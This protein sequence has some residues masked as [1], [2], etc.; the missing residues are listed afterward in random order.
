MMNG[1]D[2]TT[3]CMAMSICRISL[4]PKTITRLSASTV[5]CAKRICRSTTKHCSVNHVIDRIVK[6]HNKQE[7]ALAEKECRDPLLLPHFSV[8]VLRHTFCTR[9]CE[10]ETNIKIIQE[11]MGHADITTTMDIYNEATKEKKKESFAG[12]EGKIKIR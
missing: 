12:L 1:M 11:I 3:H 10:N 5:C 2:Y 7:T 8:H 9:F 4:I 6:E